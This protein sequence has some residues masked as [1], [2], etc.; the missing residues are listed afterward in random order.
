MDDDDRPGRSAVLSDALTKIAGRTTELGVEV[1]EI[2]GDVDDISRAAQDQMSLFRDLRAT[3]DAVNA[4]NRQVSAAARAARAVAGEAAGDAQQSR[5][6]VARSLDEI[7]ALVEGQAGLSQ[8]IGALRDA[9]GQVGKVSQQITAIARQTN[10]LALNATIEAARA[11]DAGR[12]FAVVAGEVKALAG[13]TAQAT[14][15]IEQTLADLATQTRRLVAEG[16][17]NV[18][19]AEAVRDG[20]QAIGTVI[21][22][23]SNAMI[24]LDAEAARIADTAQSIEGGCAVLADNVAAMA[25]GVTQSGAR[26]H[27]AQQR[28]SSLI[29]ATEHLMGLVVESGLETPDMPFIRAA[30][31]TAAKIGAAFED[32][33]TRGEISEADLFDRDH[34][35]VPNTDPQQYLTRY[36]SFCDRVLPAIQEPVLGSSPRINVCIAVDDHGYLP[37]HNAEFSQ[38]QGVDPLWNAAHC[39]HRRIFNDRPGMTA[40]R[41]RKPFLLQAYRRDMGGGRY[42]LTKSVATPITV[43]GRHWGALRLGYDP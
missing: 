37:T 36:T 7:R 20:T 22:A 18:A 10:L 40:A 35:A 27:D 34:R 19:R 24:E 29:E 13:Q 25:D 17:A 28:V 5:A 39:R 33:L 41:N 6:T 12:G 3:T 1:C 14:K 15:R 11:G 2:T 26:L 8:E 31:E 38:P 30:Q 9:L 43:R 4:G 16:D 32:G 21:D 42:T 23:A